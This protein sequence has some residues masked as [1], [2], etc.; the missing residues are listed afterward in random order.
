MARSTARCVNKQLFAIKFTIRAQRV[1]LCQCCVHNM[2][3]LAP[4]GLKIC[5]YRKKK[6]KSTNV[7]TLGTVEN[8]ILT[9]KASWSN[10][11]CCML[12]QVYKYYRL[13]TLSVQIK[14][15]V[16]MNLQS[17]YKAQKMAS[18]R[19]FSYFIV[20]NTAP[21]SFQFT[22]M[23][24]CSLRAQLQ[25]RKRPGQCKAIPRVIRK[26]NPAPLLDY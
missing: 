16:L 6:K 21:F 14:C 1:I 9:H 19:P 25:Q 15:F 13:F 23:T 3:L 4:D 8:Y 10:W 11:H 26:S 5:F 17:S 18:P 22:L 24:L 20:R 7:G 12:V 2:F